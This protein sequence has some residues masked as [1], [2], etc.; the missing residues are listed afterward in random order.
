MSKIIVIGG[1]A[2]GMMAAIAAARNGHQVHLYEKNEKLGKKIYI[3][4][5]GR[6]NLTN[7]SDMETVFENVVTNRKF[8]YSAF[9]NL[10]N[11]D[12]IKFFDQSGCKTK[13]E[14][15]NRVFPV[16]DHSS[17]VISA[18][19]N[20][21]KKLSV[22]THLKTEVQKIIHD[23]TNVSGIMLSTGEVVHADAVIVAT[24]GL[25]YPSTGSTGDGYRFAKDAG[26]TVTSL[27]PS[28]VSI[29]LKEEWIRNLQGLSLR[30][31]N[32]V[33]TADKPLPNVSPKDLKKVK[34]GKVLYEA[35]GELLFTHFG[36]SGPVILSA[37][38]YLI[39]YLNL[40]EMKLKIDLKPALSYE[41]LD[42]RILR[43]FEEMINKQ[44]KNALDHLLPQKLIGVIITL[45]G[46]SPEKQV[47]AI[48][49]E[50]RLNLVH[51]I[52][53]LT[54][55]IS[56]LGGYNEAVITKGGISVKEINPST[57][58]SKK[59]KGLYFCGEVLDVDALTGG[60]NLQIAW[61]TGFT[62]GNAIT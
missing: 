33:V 34:E 2:A 36:V 48:T 56:R 42:A 41:Q 31:I 32:A 1:G 19:A 9:Y 38:S 44:F 40:C 23:E 45:S 22:N 16:S 55:D 12:V 51:L 6:C 5:K 49:K 18:L 50:E 24:G 17:D 46:I 10:T 62:A 47:N 61:S 4:G 28:L 57:M 59:I 53:N 58:E 20:E 39:P 29:H 7:A 15:G 26:H 35:F 37:S 14:R 11:D 54:F 13:V 30:N 52:K 3:T 60:Y 43:D 27:N 25:S 8:L 21:M